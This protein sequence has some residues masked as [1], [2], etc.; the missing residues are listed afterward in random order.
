MARVL[1]SQFSNYI[2]Q[3]SVFLRRYVTII[4][5]QVG[6]D[7]TNGNEA[8][9]SG[10]HNFLSQL[11]AEESLQ[12]L[13]QDLITMFLQN[14]SVGDRK[15]NPIDWW[16]SNESRFPS[17]AK[18]AKTVLCINASSVASKSFSF[19]CRTPYRRAPYKTH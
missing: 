13:Y 9:T 12:R 11:L 18:L 6:S 3:D 2:I 7:G 4:E 15:S 1:D 10:S 17:I 14:R 5:A 19:F 8:S 16:R